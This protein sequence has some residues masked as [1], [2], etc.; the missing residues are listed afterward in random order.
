MQLIHV[1]HNIIFNIYVTCTVRCFY[2]I[3]MVTIL[4]FSFWTGQFTH[5]FSLTLT[6]LQNVTAHRSTAKQ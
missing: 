4:A 5:R 6:V 1:N 3:S 2:Q